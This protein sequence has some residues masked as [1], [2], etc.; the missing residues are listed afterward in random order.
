VITGI[1]RLLEAAR[2]ARFSQP[3]VELRRQ[4]LA[5]AATDNHDSYNLSH[6]FIQRLMN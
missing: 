2:V 4:Q 6:A 3:G 5:T 1:L